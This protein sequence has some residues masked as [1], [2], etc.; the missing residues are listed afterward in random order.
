MACQ[1]PECLVGDKGKRY[2]ERRYEGRIHFSHHAIPTNVAVKEQH[3]DEYYARHFA[4]AN[5]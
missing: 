4:P 5:A 2:A 3:L 1:L